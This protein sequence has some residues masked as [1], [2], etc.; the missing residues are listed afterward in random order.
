MPSDGTPRL[1]RQHKQKNASVC[2]SAPARSSN[3]L[4]PAK[5]LP[6][7]IA[8]ERTVR[9]IYANASGDAQ[10]RKIVSTTVAI[11][12]PQPRTVNEC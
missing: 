4:E 11:I 8:A 5:L 1:K 9:A 12:E 7:P 10:A 3:A 6:L 2:S